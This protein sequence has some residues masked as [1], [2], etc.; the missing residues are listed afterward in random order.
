MEI[1][2]RTW[3][4]RWSRP[5]SWTLAVAFAVALSANCATGEEMTDA[6]KACCAAMGHDCGSMAQSEDCCS[7]ESP[8][9][10]HFFATAKTTPTLAP[11]LLALPFAVLPALAAA[12]HSSAFVH[13]PGFR[14]QPSR[15]P[16]YL[17]TT[18]LLI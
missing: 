18:T 12:D 10:Q 15:V 2:M 16:K 17:L 6:Q 14:L 13:L 8:R 7:H 5:I 9:S 1:A 3:M 4:T 11:A